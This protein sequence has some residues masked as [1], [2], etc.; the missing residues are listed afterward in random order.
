MLPCSD[1]GVG[2]AFRFARVLVRVDFNVPLSFGGGVLDD[3]R[4]VAVTD[5]VNVLKRVGAKIILMSHFRRP[6]GGRDM[7]CSLSLIRRDIENVLRAKVHFIPD[8]LQSFDDASSDIVLLE[9]LRFYE[10]EELNDGCFAYQLSRV[11]DV[12]VNDA[13]SCSHRKHASV[14]KI[15]DFLPCY[16]GVN[17]YNEVRNLQFTCDSSVAVIIGGSKISTKLPALRELVKK[18]DFLI[19]GGAIA[20]SLL[21][22][23]GVS[24]GASMYEPDS[25]SMA[26]EVL[27]AARK[28]NCEVILPVDCV[29]ADDVTSLDTRIVGANAIKSTDKVFDIGPKS[30]LRC[31]DV[32][33]RCGL[34][35]FNGPVG[36]FERDVFAQGT[37]S[38][39]HSIASLTQ[40]GTL[41][42]I[43]GGGDSLAALKL[44]GIKTENFT[45]VSTAGGALLDY[46]GG[47][48]MPGLQAL[49]QGESKRST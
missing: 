4:I 47:C 26:R 39:M 10:E 2:A 1:I 37:F 40:S 43:I 8:C 44:S 9:N 24:V 5:T 38:L 7:S 35:F 17:L 49:L 27:D 25:E 33:K 19:V 45:Y 23:N 30:V 11:A 15:A 13:F 22:A 28:Y 16:A 20:L 36:V 42:S 18:T 31:V 6:K 32:I 29:C 14:S 3:S 46:I 41:K 48:D 12:Y 34:V 21:R